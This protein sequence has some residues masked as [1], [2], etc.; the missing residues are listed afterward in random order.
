LNVVA[1]AAHKKTG[2]KD[3]NK[4][5]LNEKSKDSPCKNMILDFLLKFSMLYC[6]QPIKT[7]LNLKV[8]SLLCFA[9][10]TFVIGESRILASDWLNNLISTLLFV[11][12]NTQF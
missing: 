3:N 6:F 2:T 10:V 11:R 8:T 9:N 12:D 1:N 5:K 7:I 4:N